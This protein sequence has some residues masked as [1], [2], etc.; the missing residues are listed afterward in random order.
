MSSFQFELNKDGVK[1]LL[2]SAEMQS[3]VGEYGQQILNIAGDGYEV[4]NAVGKTRATSKIHPVTAKAYYSNRK[5][6]TLQ[7]ALGSVKS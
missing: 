4:V 1:E 7:K 3:I 6:K 5:H 2:Q